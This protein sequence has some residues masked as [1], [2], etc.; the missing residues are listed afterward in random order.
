MR[1]EILFPLFAPVA[2][3]KGVGPKLL[4]LVERAAGPLV[5]DLVFLPPSA[6]VER[7]LSTTDQAQDGQT[8]TLVVR[9]VEHQ[10]ARGRRPGV[11]KAADEAGFVSLIWFKGYGPHL[12]RAH[13]VGAVRVV[14]GKVERFRQVELQMPHPD[15]MVAPDQAQ[16]VPAR[17]TVYPTTAGLPSRTLRKFV[18]EALERAPVLPEW[19]DPAWRAR[20]DW[21]DWREALEKLHASEDAAALTPGAAERRRLAYD[22]LLAHQLALARRKSERKAEPARRI[23]H[24]E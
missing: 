4:P 22:E 14:S 7:R 23:A 8:V 19:Q 13:P 3:L 10:P 21:P 9:I 20:N 2:T 11:I 18:L 17:E 16:E 6:V 1:P 5:R 12:E 24:A 15:Y